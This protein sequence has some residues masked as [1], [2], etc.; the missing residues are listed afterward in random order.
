[1]YPFVC[2]LPWDIIFIRS[3]CSL[4]YD[5]FVSSSKVRS[6]HSAI[7]CVP[8]Q[9]TASSL[10]LKV[11]RKQSK[12]AFYIQ[13]I[14]SENHAVCEIT[15]KKYGRGGQ[16]TDESMIRGMLFSCWITKATGTHSDYVIHIAFPRQ[17]WLRERASMLRYT[18][19]IYLVF[20]FRKLFVMLFLLTVGIIWIFLSFTFVDTVKLL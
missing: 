8:F 18:Y 19:I 2:Y 10:F 9:F 11:I 17:Q 12:Y 3:F 6:P 20:S 15:W 14:F 5:R 7:W 16:A 4:S 13:Q 1:V